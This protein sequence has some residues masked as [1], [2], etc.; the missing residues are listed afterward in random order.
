VIPTPPYRLSREE[1]SRITGRK[2]PA[3]I[4][5]TAIIGHRILIVL[6]PPRTKIGRIHLASTSIKLPARGH[7]IMVG[8]SVGEKWSPSGECTGRW[9]VTI[10]TPDGQVS[11]APWTLLGVRVVVWSYSGDSV[12]YEPDDS[13]PDT[14]W[15]DNLTDM[16]M[17]NLEWWKSP[18]KMVTDNDIQFFYPSTV[19]LNLGSEGGG[20]QPTEAP[21]TVPTTGATGGSDAE[22][23]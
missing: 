8:E 23:E 12:P 17:E 14:S 1:A 4:F 7:V 2:L 19:N 10:R 6:E 21:A 20:L 15:L 9:P 11:P 16:G 22:K 3:D 5:E 18:F 13:D